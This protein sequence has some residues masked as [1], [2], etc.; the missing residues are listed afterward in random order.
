MEPCL[1]LPPLSL[2]H[3]QPLSVCVLLPYTYA[4]Y[5]LYSCSTWCPYL[6][7]H[8][9]PAPADSAGRG[10][11][12]PL[13]LQLYRVRAHLHAVRVQ[14]RHSAQHHLLRLRLRAATAALRPGGLLSAPA[15]Q[16]APVLHH[17]LHVS[18]GEWGWGG[19]VPT[20][21]GGRWVR[22]VGWWS[23]GCVRQWFVRVRAKGAMDA[24]TLG[25]SGRK[26]LPGEL[27]LI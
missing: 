8:L 5:H 27:W 10:A 2:V 12:D 13:R 14:L 16:P 1:Y 7:T 19:G 18:R 21:F 15:A 20:G 3:L 6:T 25:I 9:P 26:S 11:C 4:R 22:W 24:Q 17:I 23:G